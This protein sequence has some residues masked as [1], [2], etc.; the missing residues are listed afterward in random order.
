[1]GLLLLSVILIH[2]FFTS[3]RTDKCAVRHGKGGGLQGDFLI[4]TWQIVCYDA[5]KAGAMQK[6]GNAVTGASFKNNT[7][8]K[9][10]RYLY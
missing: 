4:I 2:I 3:V 7:F 10:L 9:D 6:R 1:M 5:G 8:Q